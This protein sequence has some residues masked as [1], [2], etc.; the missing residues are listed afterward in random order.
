[1]D[2]DGAEQ[3]QSNG[4]SRLETQTGKDTN[5]TEKKEKAKSLSRISF[6]V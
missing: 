5:E 6:I 1:M 4:C 2:W 3:Q